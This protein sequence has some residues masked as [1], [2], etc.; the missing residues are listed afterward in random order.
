MYIWDFSRSV[1]AGSATTLNT[2]GLTL[3]VMRLMTPP[4]PAASRPFE[5]DDDLYAL[6]L[7][8]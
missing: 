4:L 8:P 3:S 7:H 5:D 1:G 2:L 6:V